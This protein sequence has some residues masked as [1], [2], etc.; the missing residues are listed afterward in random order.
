MIK[1]QKINMFTKTLSN[2]I[3]TNGSQEMIIHCGLGLF[4]KNS[5]MSSSRL[6][7]FGNS[8]GKSNCIMDGTS[9]QNLQF[10]FVDQHQENS[11]N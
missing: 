4:S 2:S 8:I 5:G 6:H 9:I 3:L 11:S 7:F 1:F 10:L